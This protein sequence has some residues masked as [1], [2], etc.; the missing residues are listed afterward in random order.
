MNIKTEIIR[1]TVRV[2]DLKGGD[3]V[4]INLKCIFDESAKDNWQFITVSKEDLTYSSFMGHA[5][6]GCTYRNGITKINWKVPTAYGYRY[7]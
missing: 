4:E 6:R 7:A 1:T 3:T 2:E 5:F